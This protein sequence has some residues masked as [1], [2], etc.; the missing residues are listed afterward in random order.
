MPTEMQ[1]D[2]QAKT[3]ARTASELDPQA[4]AAIRN[5]LETQPEIAPQ[6]VAER[7][8]EKAARVQAPLAK[9]DHAEPSETGSHETPVEAVAPKRASKPK[10][11]RVRPAANPGAQADGIVGRMKAALTGYRPAPKHIVLVGIALLVLL[12]PWLV[13]GLLFLSLFVFVGIF[14]ILGYDGFWRRAMGLARWY[15]QRRPSR[16]AE[17]H[18]KLD[19]FAMR[20]DSILDRFP[21]G[22]VDGLYLPDFGDLATADARHDDALDRRLNNL[23]EGEA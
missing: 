22:S 12:R 7:Q 19:A 14:L 13:V 3:T 16:A 2:T 5:L 4:L 17:M 11:K 23:R 8:A 20:W 9:P 18:R 1:S 6:P 15:A 10:T 21:E